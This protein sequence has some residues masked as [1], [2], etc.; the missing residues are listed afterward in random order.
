[1]GRF[2]GSR[3]PAWEPSRDALASLFR[4]WTRKQPEQ[5][6]MNELIE[7]EDEAEIGSIN[8]SIIQAKIT[9]MLLNDTRFTRQ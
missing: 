8:H 9:G 3:A 7:R 1:M 2:S 4:V 5:K 6:Q